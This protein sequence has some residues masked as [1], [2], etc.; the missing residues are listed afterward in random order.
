MRCN[1]KLLPPV[2]L[3]SVCR[4]PEAVAVCKT[5]QKSLAPARDGCEGKAGTWSLRFFLI[6]E[7]KK[8]ADGKV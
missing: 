8:T 4:V 1:Q 3:K 5:Q 6:T 7:A 2:T